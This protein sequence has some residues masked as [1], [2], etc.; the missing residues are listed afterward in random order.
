MGDRFILG[1]IASEIHEDLA[2]A[3]PAR[4]PSVVH[5]SVGRLRVHLPHW[6]GTRAE[7][8]VGEVRR[9]VGVTHA[10]A[11]AV[12]G[13][14]LILYQPRQTSDETLLQ[15]LPALRL[16][17]P[18]ASCEIATL[19]GEAPVATESRCHPSR[20]QAT[21]LVPKL[22]LGT[23]GGAA[24]ESA[25]YMTGWR[26][27]AYQALGW[28]SVGM[29]VVGA[30][31]PG[32]PTAPFVVLAGYFF[33]RSSPE[34][35]QWLRQSRWF[36]TI[37]RDWEDHRAIRRSVRNAALGLIA[38]SMVLT[39]LLGLPTPLLVTIIAL[40]TLG[41]AVILSLRVVEAELTPR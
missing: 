35:H 11:S 32:I 40:Q 27:V 10:E 39:S 23:R 30:I 7:E 38:I 25:G 19:Q 13:N 28:T 24:A 15:A 36:G 20:S 1:Q 12:T 8:I 17:P 16:D 4:E 22:S 21:P 2:E 37:L 41:L 26:R 18:P 33:I 3:W 9:L 5:S 34:A 29:A 14:L 31:L 6:S